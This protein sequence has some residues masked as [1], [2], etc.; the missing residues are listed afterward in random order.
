MSCVSVVVGIGNYGWIMWLTRIYL[1]IGT[2][3]LRAFESFETIQGRLALS[4][5]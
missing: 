4:L 5:H 1:M 3:F 2:C